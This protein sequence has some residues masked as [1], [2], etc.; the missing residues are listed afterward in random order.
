MNRQHKCAYYM[1]ITYAYSFKKEPAN[2]ST[3]IRVINALTALISSN[4]HMLINSI[5]RVLEGR[6]VDFDLKTVASLDTDKSRAAG[7]TPTAP[8][9]L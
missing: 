3:Q 9:V 4:N 8:C 6:P 1:I 7:L 5:P 2:R